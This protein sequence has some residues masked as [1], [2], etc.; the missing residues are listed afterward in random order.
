MQCWQFGKL[1]R[2]SA[3]TPM[4][5]KPFLLLADDEPS[6]LLTLR[7]IFEQKGY[8]ITTAETAAEA[9]HHLSSG[10][11][12]DAVVTDLCMERD[13]IGLEVARAAVKLR[14][15]PIIV[16][17][18]GFS[19]VENAQAALHIG[20]D[21]YAIKPLEAEELHTSVDRLLKSRKQLKAKAAQ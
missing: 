8:T 5:H 13:D 6:V 12:F 1:S 10:T 20:V 17:L 4:R 21:Y 19:S 11:R 3:R 9:L 7:M 18:T 2:R 14:P 16:V 15:R